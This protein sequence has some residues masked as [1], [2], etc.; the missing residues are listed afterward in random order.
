MQVALTET[1]HTIRTRSLASPGSS[2]GTA[3]SGVES[4]V[5]LQN[6]A[7]ASA[8]LTREDRLSRQAL[9][10]S[11]MRTPGVYNY[12]VFGEKPTVAERLGPQPLEDRAP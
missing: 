2:V 8:L 4:L 9:A 11:L 6:P 1:R 12:L 10:S 5:A 7:I 3:T